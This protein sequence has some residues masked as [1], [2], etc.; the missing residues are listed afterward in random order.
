MP[1]QLVSFSPPLLS[2][3]RTL[4]L[5]LFAQVLTAFERGSAVVAL[6]SLRPLSLDGP[7]LRPLSWL[8][9]LVA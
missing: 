6:A 4:K 9:S 8:R 3:G 2:V 5:T 7:L 1:L